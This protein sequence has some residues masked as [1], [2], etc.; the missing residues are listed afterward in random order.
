MA[1]LQ[2]KDCTVLEL[3]EGESPFPSPIRIALVEVL[4]AI[5]NEKAAFALGGTRALEKELR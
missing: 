1:S 4:N 5:D 3:S 2:C